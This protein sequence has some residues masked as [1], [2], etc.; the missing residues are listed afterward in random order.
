MG[1]CLSSSTVDDSTDNESNKLDYTDNL[2]TMVDKLSSL[3]DTAKDPSNKIELASERNNFFNSRTEGDAGM[4]DAIRSGLEAEER[5]FCDTLLQSAELT[6][7]EADSENRWIFTYDPRGTRYIVP[8]HIFCSPADLPATA[9]K[10]A[11]PIK[12]AA[13]SLPVI[14]NLRYSNDKHDNTI[15]TMTNKYISDLITQVAKGNKL[16]AAGIHI[17][18]LGKFYKGNELVAELDA[19]AKVQIFVDVNAQG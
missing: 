1:A 18:Q 19:K 2:Q 14:L 9:P 7:F 16:D 3:Y 15:K 8:L 6:P 11:K 5:S 17:A 12:Q 13:R 4:W 10:K